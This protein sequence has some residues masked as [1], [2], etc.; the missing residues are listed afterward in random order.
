MSVSRHPLYSALVI[1][2]LLLLRAIGSSG[3]QEPSHNSFQLGAEFNQAVSLLKEGNLPSAMSLV[4]KILAQYPA[5]IPS[6][7][8]QGQLLEESGKL[9][10]AQHSF[11]QAEKIDPHNPGV[12]FFLGSHWFKRRNWDQ[13]TAYFERCLHVQPD[14]VDTLVLASDAYRAKNDLV[15]ALKH[16]EKAVG[17]APRNAG[18]C[19][20]YGNLFCL[21]GNNEE[22][23]VWLEKAQ[24]LDPKLKNLDFEIGKTRTLLHYNL[25]AI[26]ALQRAGQQRPVS[27][28]IYF[29]LGVNF[30]KLGEWEKARA[31]Y[32][33]CLQQ[34]PGNTRALCG[35]GHSLSMLKQ[36]AEAENYLRQALLLDPSLAEAHAHLG[37][38]YRQLNQKEQAVREQLIFDSVS[39]SQAWADTK[40]DTFEKEKKEVWEKCLQLVKENQEEQAL[41]LLKTLPG[42]KTTTMA[43]QYYNLGAIYLSLNRLADAKRTLDK[44]RSLNP[45][46]R[47][48]N[49]TLGMV[50]LANKDLEEAEKAF[51]AELTSHPDEE[52]ALLGLAW[53]RFAQERWEEAAAY[54]ERS[55]TKAPDSL[56]LLCDAYFHLGRTEQGLITAETLAAIAPTD[57]IILESLIDLLQRRN[58]PELVLRIQ[59]QLA[60][61]S[62]AAPHYR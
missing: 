28:E 49:S 29:W 44:A 58:Q 52:Q 20:K 2:W 32:S 33:K 47:G 25:K 3:D 5:H 62:E 36:Y 26:E 45:N 4:Q 6:L 61:Q 10:L 30:E 19:Q 42:V 54:L 18:I 27:P 39:Q 38:L 56:L 46:G 55:K 21:S 51:Q 12:L 31:F 43:N 50:Y 11:E 53:L 57:Q 23:L 34:D 8:L 60:K 7:L 37:R 15:P 35:L 59:K 22:G 41:A 17:L 13:A 24:Q 1:T 9:E 16:I 14:N 40:K 48:V